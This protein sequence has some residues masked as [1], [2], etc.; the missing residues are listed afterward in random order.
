MM[1]GGIGVYQLV[2]KII[3]LILIIDEYIHVLLG[4]VV[5]LVPLSPLVRIPRGTMRPRYIPLPCPP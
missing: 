2:M 5:P 4:I 1:A 3:F